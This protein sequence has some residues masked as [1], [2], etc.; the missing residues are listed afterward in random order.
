M[1]IGIENSYLRSI[2]LTNL[3]VYMIGRP[4]EKQEL[5]ELERNFKSFIQPHLSEKDS[6][7]YDLVWQ[8]EKYIF[9]KGQQEE[10]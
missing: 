5:S 3:F 9:D 8:M 4:M 6:E 1:T 10:E 7:A 2:R